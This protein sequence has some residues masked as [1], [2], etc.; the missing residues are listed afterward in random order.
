MVYRM[1]EK[2]FSADY[3]PGG[4]FY[5]EKEKVEHA[6]VRKALLKYEEKKNFFGKVITKGYVE[7]PA[8]KKKGITGFNYLGEEN[9]RR[10]YI[11]KG[12]RAVNRGEYAVALT[13][14]KEGYERTREPY[15]NSKDL[16]QILTSLNKGIG[17]LIRKAG[18]A[19]KNS[20]VERAYELGKEVA[21]DIDNLAEKEK[22]NP[23]KLEEKLT[24]IIAILSLGL[25]ISFL[26]FNITGYSVMNV[27]GSGSN[28]ILGILLI[29]GLVSAFLYIR[30]N[31][32]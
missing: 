3:E 28:W 29:L 1:V 30:K 27:N 9:R 4:K 13:N 18:E 5:N 22:K 10:F 8:Y 17:W 32:F 26:S 2:R 7:Q 20:I 31:K 25:A 12:N 15:I 6:K 24:L 23:G 19:R 16:V 14:Y 21:K 11:A